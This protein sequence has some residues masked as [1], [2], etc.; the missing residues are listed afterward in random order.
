M[1]SNKCGQCASVTINGVFC[2]EY[3]C[4]NR[5]RKRKDWIK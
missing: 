1:A 3:G 5:G 2:H 4:P